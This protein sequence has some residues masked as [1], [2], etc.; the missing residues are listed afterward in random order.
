M[1]KKF[2]P[3]PCQNAEEG[4][5]ETST[6]SERRW[7]STKKRIVGMAVMALL[8]LSI[9]LASLNLVQAQDAPPIVPRGVQRVDDL[10]GYHFDPDYVPTNCQGL[11]SSYS[12]STTGVTLTTSA[13]IGPVVTVYTTGNWI[14]QMWVFLNKFTGSYRWSIEWAY[15]DSAGNWAMGYILPHI[16]ASSYPSISGNFYI[17]YVSSTN[18]WWG[19]VYVSTTGQTYSKNFGSA[20]GSYVNGASQD[21]VAVETNENQVGITFSSSFQWRL[22]S[23]QFYRGGYWQSYNV[24]IGD[25]LYLYLRITFQT[26]KPGN[27]V[28]VWELTS[29]GVKVYIGASRS[30]NQ[31]FSWPVG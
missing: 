6:Q 13:Y 30:N 22:T 27:T 11:K 17:Y 16:P 23:P 7:K 24:R 18:S 15:R 21:W 25:Y 19:I 28:G 5:N 4:P 31:I 10:F 20:G 3:Y 12:I 14:L 9:V 26:N 29:P 8:M 2:W 1:A